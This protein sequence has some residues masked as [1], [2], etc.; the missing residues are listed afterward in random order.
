[1]DNF[2]DTFLALWLH[3]SGSASTSWTIQRA[4][5]YNV[6]GVPTVWFDG[7]SEEVGAAGSDP[8]Q[9]SWYLGVYNTR[10]DVRT[11]VTIDLSATQVDPNTFDIDAEVGLEAGAPV[12]RDLAVHIVQVLDYYPSSTD[13]RYRNCARKNNTV[14]NITLDPNESTTVSWTCQ[15]GPE[16]LADPNNVRIISFVRDQGSPSP[17]QIWQSAVL[18]WPLVAEG[19][20]NPGSSGNYCEADVY[21]NNGDGSWDYAD[22]GDC[23][24]NSSDL[25]QLLANY[26][27]TSGMTREDGDIYPTGGGDGQVNSSDLGEL[28][29]QY[30]DDC[31]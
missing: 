14:T 7:V 2:P 25:G 8:L 24:V 10:K 20:A 23:I 22:D 26:G 5:W 9:Y 29:A 17:K 13:D 12:S 1:M 30:N 27:T 3:T 4:N 16:S 18:D 31:N 11:D 15:L 21:P 19:C 6:G 28:L